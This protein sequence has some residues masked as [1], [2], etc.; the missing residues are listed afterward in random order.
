[1]FFQDGNSLRI[2]GDAE[3]NVVEVSQ[4]DSGQTIVTGIDTTVN[5]QATPQAVSSNGTEDLTVSLGDGND[6]ISLIDIVVGDTVAIV[7]RRRKRSRY[8]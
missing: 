4:D 3:D 5:G 7:G 1:M 6:E 8:D 2:V